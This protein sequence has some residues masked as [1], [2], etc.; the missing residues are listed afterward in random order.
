MD[1]RKHSEAMQRLTLAGF[2]VALVGSVA[3]IP[4]TAMATPL[5]NCAALAAQLLKNG[6]I[7]SATSA[8]QP[9]T[10]S[11]LSYC[12]VSITVSDLAG[13]KDGYLPGQKQMIEIAIGLP[14]S[15]T[16]GGIGGVQGNWNGRNENLGGGGYAGS[17]DSGGFPVTVATDAGYVGTDTDTGHESSGPDG[18]ALDGT[19]ALNPNGTLNWGLINDFAYNGIHDQSV[20]GKKV[21]Q[22]YYGRGPVYNYWNGCSTGGRQGH[23]QAQK[24]PEDFDGILAGS[25]AFNWDRFIPSEQWA[26]IVMNQEVG[27]PIST[28]KLN[29][30]TAAAIAACDSL[31]GILDGIVQDPRACHYD[32]KAFV[33]KG[34]PS[35]PANCL[36]PNEA[37][38]VNKIWNGPYGKGPKIRQASFGSG[39]PEANDRLWFGLERDAPLTSLA[40]ATPF[41]ISTEWFQYWLFQ[42][43]AFNWQTLT[44]SSFVP[45]F[46]LSE[47]KFHQVL[48][49]DNPDLSAFRNRG[50]RIITY[51]G[52]AD[53][54]IFPRGTYNYYNRVTQLQGGIPEVQKFYRFF[55]YPGNNH[56]GG[57]AT[58]PNAPL[59]NNTDLFNALVNWVEHGKAPDYILAY[60][61]AVESSATFSRPICKYP[62]TL[63]Y[64]GNGS[65][66][67]AASF[68]CKV[69]TTDPLMD[70]EQVVPDIGPQGP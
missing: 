8:V 57:N 14:L 36:Q 28:A 2:A 48:G 47:Q 13:V 11:D 50:G 39:G 53:V 32:A 33:C 56:C 54:V 67:S 34:S 61:N 43:P 18:G 60:N 21:A 35:D 63:I 64:N 26:P 5:P 62:D 20:W 59:I 51:H 17:L 24:Y 58:E 7:L 41:P 23:Q 49:T 68:T 45:A 40:G 22:M 15:A 46:F 30:V 27:A 3:F 10:A 16:D 42:N 4:S 6:D 19:F 29:A 31:D 66:S 25:N 52:L 44:E 9:A 12:L 65:I 1:P 70:A 37:D 69:N 55:P 38:A